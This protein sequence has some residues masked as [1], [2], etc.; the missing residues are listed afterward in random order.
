MQANV[1]LQASPVSGPSVKI[2]YQS[3]SRWSLILLPALSLVHLL[4]CDG[5]HVSVLEMFALVLLKAESTK[6]QSDVSLL[7]QINPTRTNGE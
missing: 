1:T 2:N 7:I 6:P 4:Q 3:V 5:I